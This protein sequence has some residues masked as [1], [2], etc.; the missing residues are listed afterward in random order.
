MDDHDKSAVCFSLHLVNGY[1]MGNAGQKPPSNFLV[2]GRHSDK[3]SPA[4]LRHN[5]EMACNV[6]SGT[7]NRT[8]P[9]TRW[10]TWIFGLVDIF[11][12]WSALCKPAELSPAGALLDDAVHLSVCWFVRLSVAEMRTCRAL[13]C[14]AQ[15]CYW[16]LRVHTN[17]TIFT[18]PIYCIYVESS[19]ISWTRT[20][21]PP[22]RLKILAALLV[23]RWVLDEC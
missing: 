7:L 22:P 23:K 2:Q 11:V 17:L 4:C 14:P 19:V 8:M 10:Y 1:V 5:L 20:P 3:V 18:F 16:S 6:S 13:V 15:Q 12:S 21:C 9:Y